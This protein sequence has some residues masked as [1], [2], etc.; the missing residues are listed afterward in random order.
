[1]STDFLLTDGVATIYVSNASGIRAHADEDSGD[2]SGGG[3]FGLGGYS[4]SPGLH[5]LMQRHGH[6]ATGF[7]G[8]NRNL[9]AREG[10]FAVG[11]NIAALGVVAGAAPNL[12]MKPVRQDSLSEAQMV[13]WSSNDKQSWRALIGRYQAV[14]I[15]D[16][17]S[18]VGGVVLPGANYAPPMQQAVQQQPMA[19]PYGQPQPQPQVAYAQQPQPQP[20]YAN[21]PQPQQAYAQPQQPQ[22][23]YAQPQQPQQAYAQP[24]QPQQAYAQP[25]QPQQ[26][27]AQPQQPQGQHAEYDAL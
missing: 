15:S 13:G 22:Q 23:A 9:R 4:A 14:L 8:M 26:A 17:P 18:A 16:D 27:Y 12:T 21:Q 5:Q 6:S 3:F 25:Q 19:V 24:Q 1:M 20:G 7:F 11:E 10:V 2:S